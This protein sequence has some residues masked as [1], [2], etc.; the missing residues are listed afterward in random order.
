[1]ILNGALA[2]AVRWA[3]GVQEGADMPWARRLACLL[4]LSVAA[5]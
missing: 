5:I 3:E 2:R 4:H 1:M